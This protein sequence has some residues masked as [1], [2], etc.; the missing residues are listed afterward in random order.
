MTENQLTTLNMN[1][2]QEQI[3]NRIK[4]AFVE[5]I[6]DDSWKNLVQAEID[7]WTTDTKE[8]GTIKPSP[9]KALI[10]KE[11][12]AKVR[13]V[14]NEELSKPE[15]QFRYDGDSSCVPGKAIQE[16]IEKNIYQF[17]KAAYGEI[18]NQAVSNMANYLRN[19]Q[20]GY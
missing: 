19:K 11:V 1:D 15:Y 12:E 10:A 16:V 3:K 20:S 14:I 2:I 7:K 9:L 8:Y 4:S 18:V 5:L 6:P 13:E 17:V